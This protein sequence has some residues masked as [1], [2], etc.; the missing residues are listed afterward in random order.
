VTE[1]NVLK[2]PD[3]LERRAQKIEAAMKRRENGD[4]EWIEGTLELAVELAGARAELQADQAFGKW[5]GSRFG[6]NVIPRDERAILVQW[7]QNPEQ[8]RLMLEKAESHSIQMIDRRFRSA[9]KPPKVSAA[10]TPKR[11]AAAATIRAQKAVTGVYPTVAQAIKASGLSRIVIEPALA[12]VKA[13]DNI[14]PTE[15]RLTKA[16]N[17]FIEA[18]IKIRLQE[19]E[20]TFEARV[21][22]EY[23]CRANLMFPMLQEI[24]DRVSIRDKYLTE[25]LNKSAVFTKA[26]YID[27]LF[28]VRNE[29]V[30]QE[31]RDR[32][33]IALE[34]KKIRLVGVTEQT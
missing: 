6:T 17:A 25:Q 27:V 11:T 19:L 3:R 31:R 8:T 9:T 5:C 22:A 12:T 23:Q 26:E 7:G 24:K 18:T 15:P 16:D 10:T 29:H 33:T 4:K 20:K 32:A 2:M 13:E 30:S 28:C 1:D 34:T 21:L 14:A